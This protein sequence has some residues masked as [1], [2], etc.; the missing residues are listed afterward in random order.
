[1]IN[2]D[3]SRPMGMSHLSSQ[4]NSN[5]FYRIVTSRHSRNRKEY[6][7]TA[8]GVMTAGEHADQLGHYD[9]DENLNLTHDH[10]KM[11]NDIIMATTDGRNNRKG[12]NLTNLTNLSIKIKE[13]NEPGPKQKTERSPKTSLTNL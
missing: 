4:I 3:N 11:P 5:D 13:V 12:F 7:A 2:I 10:I 6:L 9:L 1:M 8:G